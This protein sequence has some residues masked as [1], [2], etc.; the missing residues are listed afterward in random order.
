LKRQNSIYYENKNISSVISVTFD[1]GTQFV[2]TSNGIRE[3]FAAKSFKLLKNEVFQRQQICFQ[4]DK[5]TYCVN[6]TSGEI[7]RQQ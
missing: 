6:N 1:K 2:E 4:A 3:T 7:E 5:T